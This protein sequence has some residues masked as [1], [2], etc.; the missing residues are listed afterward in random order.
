[1]KAPL[2]A[3]VATCPAAATPLQNACL[4]PTPGGSRGAAASCWW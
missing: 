4:L 2:G 3:G 1:L